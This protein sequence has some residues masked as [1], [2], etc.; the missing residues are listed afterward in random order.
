[1]F[2]VMMLFVYQHVVMLY[3]SAVHTLLCCSVVG[4]SDSQVDV[5]SGSLKGRVHISMVTDTCTDGDSPLSNYK[6]NDIIKA[7]VLKIRKSPGHPAV[8]ELC[9]RQRY[10]LSPRVYVLC[11]LYVCECVC[12]HVCTVH[13]SYI[14]YNTHLHGVCIGAVQ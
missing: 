1:M 9:T 4:V 6:P 13:R 7:R 14:L 10:A 5:R 2:L 11:L 8:L 12:S 3:S